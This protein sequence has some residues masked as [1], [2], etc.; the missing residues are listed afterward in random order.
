[1]DSYALSYHQDLE[2]E[3]G[4]REGGQGVSPLLVTYNFI[5]TGI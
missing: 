3:V 1:M 4:G 5:K 2:V